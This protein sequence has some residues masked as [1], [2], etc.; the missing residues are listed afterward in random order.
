M[1]TASNSEIKSGA[2]TALRFFLFSYVYLA[3]L[4]FVSWQINTL[5]LLWFGVSVLTLSASMMLALWHQSTIRRQIFS[6][7]FKPNTFL[8]RWSGRR[9]WSTLFLSTCAVVLSGLT[10]LQAAYFGWP[11]WTL[12][13]VSPIVFRAIY[14]PISSKTDAQFSKRIYALRWTFRASQA[15]FVVVLTV[16]YLCISCINAGPPRIFFLDRVYELQSHWGEAQSSIVKWLLDAGAFGQAAQEAITSIPNHLYWKILGVFFFAPL[17]VF[18]TLALTY[19]GISLS[20]NEFRRTI[21]NGFE[22]DE[23]PAKIGPVNSAVW[24]AVM[25]VLIGSYFQLLAYTNQSLKADESPFAIRPMEPCEKID[26][27]AYQV[28]TLKT[29]E[30]L[31][32]AVSPKLVASNFKSCQELKGLEANIASGVDDYLDWYFSLGADY[33]R[34][35]MMLTGDTEKY[36]SGK[37]NEI[38][39]KQLQQDKTFVKLRAEYE[40]QFN[41]LHAANDAIRKLLSDNRLSLHDRSCKVVGEKSMQVMSSQLGSANARLSTSAAAAMIGGV[42]ASKLT[43]KVM[44]KSTF[45]LSGKVLAKVIAKKAGG[46]AGGA[47]VGAAAGAGVGSIAPGVGTA[48]GA[49]V[50]AVTGFVVGVAIDM[51]ALAIEEGLTR[52]NMRKD[53]IESVTETLMPIRETFS[54]S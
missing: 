43:T 21:G 1:N 27:V 47:L 2:A 48:I 3:I 32:A 7:Q 4:G 23:K 13:S 34:L 19:S 14:I 53:L 42:F 9:V 10:L 28:N 6:S 30:S 54:C 17:T 33:A 16:M 51:A 52:E 18:S 20:L 40:D 12:L 38:A 11:E 39:L 49:V 24:A 46:K 8:Y 25:V 44:T 29:V 26:G 45:K 22:A 15:I 5:N 31:I 35:A 36:L 50:G 37:F 41:T